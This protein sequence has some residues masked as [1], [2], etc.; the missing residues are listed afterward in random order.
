MELGALVCRPR[1]PL[2]PECPLAALCEAKRLSLQRELPVKAPRK[3]VPHHEV[4]AAVIGRR[5]EILITRRPPHG[6]LGGLWEFPGGKR[7]PGETLEACLRREIRE[8][9]GIAITVGERLATVKHAYTHFRITL[10]AFA[11]RSQGG[12]IRC[13]GVDDYCWI[14]PEELDRFALPAADHKL[15]ALLKPQWSRNACV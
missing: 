1:D 9:L 2:C 10:H 4:T 11:C 13:L 3:P 12:R 8:E 15:I 5:E 14:R 6:L 7:E